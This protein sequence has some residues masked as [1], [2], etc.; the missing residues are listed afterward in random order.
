MIDWAT[1]LY[2][3]IAIAN[4]GGYLL[5]V[6]RNRE[7]QEAEIQANELK[8]QAENEAKARQSALEEAER[9][10]RLQEEEDA[11]ERAEVLR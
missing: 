11:R 10:R 5:D 7:A 1:E 9:A 4:G 2:H 8:V 3:A 6:E